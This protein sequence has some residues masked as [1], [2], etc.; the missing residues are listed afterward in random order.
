M[1][2]TDEE[3]EVLQYFNGRGLVLVGS[4]MNPGIKELGHITW[5]A[6]IGALQ[7]KGLLEANDTTREGKPRKYV[8]ITP[9]GARALADK[10]A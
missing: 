7:V 1:K 10:D 2:L 9:A 3:L 6:G 4:E 5:N 8:Q